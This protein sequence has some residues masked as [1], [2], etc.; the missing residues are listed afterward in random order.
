MA[1][2]SEEDGTLRASK[3]GWR[4][5]PRETSTIHDLLHG[6]EQVAHDPSAP[7]GPLPSL[8]MEHVWHRRDDRAARDHTPTTYHKT[9]G[10]GTLLGIETLAPQPPPDGEDDEAHN[11]RAKLLIQ[12]EGDAPVP[13]RSQR[14]RQMTA[15][16]PGSSFDSSGV[17]LVHRW[18]SQRLRKGLLY[19]AGAHS[20]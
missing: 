4:N 19:A 13:E 12:T 1:H 16:D 3:K 15:D 20:V 17:D 10:E 5:G 9:A 8:A 14:R 7:K 18:A 2:V 11:H 6:G